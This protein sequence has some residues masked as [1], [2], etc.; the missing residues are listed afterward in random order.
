MISKSCLVTLAG[1]AEVHNPPVYLV[2]SDPYKYR[3]AQVVDIFDKLPDGWGP[4][5]ILVERLRLLSQ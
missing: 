3:G 2:I 4:R 1:Y 5:C